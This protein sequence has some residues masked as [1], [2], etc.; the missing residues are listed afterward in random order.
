VSICADW[1][2]ESTSKTKISQLDSSLTI[3]EQILRLEVAV[4]NAM[5]VAEGDSLQ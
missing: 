5:G 3:D 1:D 4:Q 2:A